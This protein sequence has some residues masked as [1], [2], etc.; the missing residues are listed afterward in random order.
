MFISYV[1]PNLKAFH[2]IWWGSWYFNFITPYLT[3]SPSPARD[4]VKKW[5]TRPRSHVGLE[6]D[7]S[8]RSWPFES[9]QVPY[10]GPWMAMDGH[11]AI[12]IPRYHNVH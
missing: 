2:Q 6:S 4:G 3:D 1:I 9:Q 11:G 7:V 5:R 10:G 12:E 8:H